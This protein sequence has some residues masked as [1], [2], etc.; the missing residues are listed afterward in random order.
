MEL[1]K[2]ITLETTVE[3]MLT[4]TREGQTGLAQAGLDPTRLGLGQ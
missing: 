3:F 1:I 2:L 4:Q